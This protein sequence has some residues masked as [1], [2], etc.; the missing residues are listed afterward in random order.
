[1]GLVWYLFNAVFTILMDP[2]SDCSA[3]GRPITLASIESKLPEFIRTSIRRILLLMCSLL[4]N[5]TKSESYIAALLSAVTA[6]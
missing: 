4:D 5:K 1:M 3:P 2:F 6:V